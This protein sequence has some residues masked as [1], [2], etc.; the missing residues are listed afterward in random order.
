L[1][2][3]AGTADLARGRVG[4][5]TNE[6]MGQPGNGKTFPAA[7]VT[8]ANGTLPNQSPY[9]LNGGQQRR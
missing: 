3:N 9:L 7:V 1:N 4:D 6:A 5:A 8:T 2:A